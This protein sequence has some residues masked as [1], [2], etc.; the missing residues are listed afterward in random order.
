[1]GEITRI[2]EW[3][4]THRQRFLGEDVGNEREWLSSDKSSGEDDSP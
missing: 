4:K 3:T 2:I 1:M